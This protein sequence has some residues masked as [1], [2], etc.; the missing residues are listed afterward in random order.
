MKGIM[1][2]LG[3]R[4]CFCSL[5]LAAFS[6]ADCA[7]QGLDNSVRRLLGIIILLALLFCVNVFAHLWCLYD[8][9]YKSRGKLHH[10]CQ[11]HAF[12]ENKMYG[13]AKVRAYLNFE[14]GFLM[15]HLVFKI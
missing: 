13:N 5:S 11:E 1:C 9:F 8:S 14:S 3:R 12:L 2:L 10:W 15:G 6:L 4:L 7:L